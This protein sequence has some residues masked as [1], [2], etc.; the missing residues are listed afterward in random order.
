MIH[1]MHIEMDFVCVYVYVQFFPSSES[2][3]GFVEKKNEIPKTTTIYEFHH[4][5]NKNSCN[6]VAYA[7]HMKLFSCLLFFFLFFTQN[8]LQHLSTAIIIS[9][10]LEHYIFFSFLF[11]S[12]LPSFGLFG[13]SHAIS[14][15][16]SHR[17]HSIYIFT[18]F[19]QLMPNANTLCQ[20]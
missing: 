7:S 20:L 4:I 15:C 10:L 14:F 12:S 16:L 18:A 2:F 13:F 17:T 8:I 11:T 1:Y 5:F 3:V 6:A 9:T 19:D